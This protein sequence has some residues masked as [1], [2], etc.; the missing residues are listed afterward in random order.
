MFFHKRKVSEEQ[1]EQQR[2]NYDRV[3]WVHEHASYMTYIDDVRFDKDNIYIEGPHVKGFGKKDDKFL[4]LDCNGEEVGILKVL[5]WDTKKQSTLL[6]SVNTGE[7]LMLTAD[8]VS[9][10]TENIRLASMIVNLDIF[11]NKN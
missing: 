5:D 4:L 1:K 2:Q 8:I 10:E 7:Y 11:E 3:M 6:G 9:G